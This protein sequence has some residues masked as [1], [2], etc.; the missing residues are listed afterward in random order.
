MGYVPMGEGKTSAGKG[1]ETRQS[2]ISC[3]GR[4]TELSKRA[5]ASFHRAVQFRPSWREPYIYIYIV[6]HGSRRKMGAEGEDS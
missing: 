5:I 6:I 3:E 2:S 4:G 1:I